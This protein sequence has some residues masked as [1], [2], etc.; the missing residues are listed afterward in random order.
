MKKPDLLVILALVAAL[1]ATITSM[2]AEQQKP[3]SVI[4]SESSIR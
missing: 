2:S 4:A 1:G 3:S